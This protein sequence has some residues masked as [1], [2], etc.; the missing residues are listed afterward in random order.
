MIG[1]AF[2][3]LILWTFTTFQDGSIRGLSLEIAAAAVFLGGCILIRP[4]GDES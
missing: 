4:G 1:I 3:L 2:P